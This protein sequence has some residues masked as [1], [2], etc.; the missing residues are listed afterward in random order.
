MPSTMWFVEIKKETCS[1]CQKA[2]RREK[3]VCFHFDSFVLVDFFLRNIPFAVHT[4]HTNTH[5]PCAQSSG[6]RTVEGDIMR[7]LV[8]MQVPRR[9]SPCDLAP[10]LFD[11]TGEFIGRCYHFDFKR[12][13]RDTYV[14]I[15]FDQAYVESQQLLLCQSVFVWRLQS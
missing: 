3:T 9:F 15:T 14:A 1:D 10:A 11:P 8:L 2:Y 12:A 5:Q 6:I 7:A 13:I 4:V